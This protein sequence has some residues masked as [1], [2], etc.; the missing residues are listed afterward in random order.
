MTL[1]EKQAT[2]TGLLPMLIN[3]IYD[4]GYRPRIAFVKRCDECP[5]GHPKSCH[6]VCLAVDI[7]IDEGKDGKW[8][9]IAT[10]EHPIWRVLGDYWKSLHPMFRAGVDFK[11]ANHFSMEHE[12]IS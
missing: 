1:S 8:V 6:K 3:K 2:F 9:W 7:N 12:G 11:D 4:L 10:G 5:V